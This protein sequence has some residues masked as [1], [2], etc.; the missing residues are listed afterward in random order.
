MGLHKAFFQ[1][2]VSPTLLAIWETNNFPK[3]IPGIYS[4]SGWVYSLWK[5]GIRAYFASLVFAAISI[6]ASTFL[7]NP[8]PLV[9]LIISTMLIVAGWQNCSYLRRFVKDCNDLRVVYPSSVAFLNEE[10][11]RSRANERMVVISTQV[12]DHEYA[13]HENISSESMDVKH[14]EMLKERLEF[15][16]TKMKDDF[17]LLKKFGLVDPDGY[18]LYYKEAQ[19]RRKRLQGLREATVS[20]S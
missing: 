15:N 17:D 18:Q 20:A 10:G 6:T 11:L 4:G 13:I 5:S 8:V 1:S 3:H 16:R 7:S 2:E 14:I 19:E 12:L 9:L